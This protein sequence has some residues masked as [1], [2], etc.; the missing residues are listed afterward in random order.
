MPPS[1]DLV[2]L[3]S[4]HSPH[5]IS[6]PPRIQAT[7][8]ERGAWA[9]PC[10]LRGGKP[11]CVIRRSCHCIRELDLPGASQSPGLPCLPRESPGR[12]DIG[13]VRNKTAWPGA[14]RLPG[15]AAQPASR[16]SRMPRPHHI[17]PRGSG[18]PAPTTPPYSPREEASTKVPRRP[19]DPSP[20]TPACHAA[21]TRI[22]PS[23]WGSEAGG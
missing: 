17:F 16:S 22:C 10:A 19:A 4:S 20:A 18:A 14:G 3:S 9:E 6:P 13:T 12:W 23:Q 5:P 15:A 2:S 7:V 1:Q 11:G 21:L 8:P